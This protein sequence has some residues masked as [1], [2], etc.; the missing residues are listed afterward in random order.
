MKRLLVAASARRV[1]VSQVFTV[2][3]LTAMCVALGRAAESAG[4]V[5]EVPTAGG[6]LRIH[7]IN[8]ATLALQWKG[9]TIYVDPVGG[10]GA[11]RGLP[12]PDLIL[13]T[14][15]HFDHLNKETLT[16]VVRPTT[17]LVAPPAVVEQLPAELRARA[18]VLSNGQSRV[19]ADLKLE[20]VAAYNL[21][22]DRMKFHAQGRGNGYVLALG[23]KRVYLS[24]DT[25]DTPEMRA[26][27]DI[28]VAFLCMNLPYTMDVE[29][30]ARAVRAFKPKIVYP[31]H[32]RGADLEKFK[33]LVGDA[34]G[35]EV[36]LRDWYKSPR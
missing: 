31:Y 22:P 17:Q 26:L 27:K 3:L 12:A 19:V 34:D 9:K 11:F 28:D 15:V 16:A 20:A 18:I 32:Y 36:R 10:A 6:D 8:H 5:D 29:Q 30:A 35:V 7:P 1:T 23:G 33:R 24:G 2:L 13:L 21:T 25:E 14:D 4:S